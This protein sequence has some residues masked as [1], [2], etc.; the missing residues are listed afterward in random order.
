VRQL[1][2]SIRTGQP[3]PAA[4]EFKLVHKDGSLVPV[5]IS[6]G[7][8]PLDAG[9]VCVLLIRPVGAQLHAHVSLLEADRIGLV[10]A[11]AAGFA[12]EI[13]NPLTSMLLNLRSLRKQL[14]APG[15]KVQ[16][17]AEAWLASRA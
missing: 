17:R 10:G 1:A 7:V 11:L 4:L 3:V 6:M 2:T 14:A 5:E 16:A 9:A 15:S 13:N 8:Q 12:H